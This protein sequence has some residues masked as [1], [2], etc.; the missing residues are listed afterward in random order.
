MFTESSVCSQSCCVRV[1]RRPWGFNPPTI[2]FIT[3]GGHSQICLHVCVWVYLHVC[4][5]LH[6]LGV[7]MCMCVHAPDPKNARIVYHIPGVCR[8]TGEK[9]KPNRGVHSLLSSPSTGCPR[10]KIGR[11]GVQ[12]TLGE[13]RERCV[14]FLLR[15]FSVCTVTECVLWSVMAVWHVFFSGS[16]QCG[17]EQPHCDRLFKEYYRFYLN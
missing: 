16:A 10:Q 17:R 15:V 4:A 8:E 5:C 14:C 6:A 11:L 3:T 13:R 12:I 1:W 7:R 2:L 9:P